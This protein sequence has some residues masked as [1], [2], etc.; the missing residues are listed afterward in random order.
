MCYMKC[1]FAW[2]G[3]IAKYVSR[4]PNP[5]RALFFN[6]SFSLVSRQHPDELPARLVRSRHLR[7]RTIPSGEW[8]WSWSELVR[9]LFIEPCSRWWGR[10]S[11]RRARLKASTSRGY[12]PSLR[13]TLPWSSAAAT[14]WEWTS[15]QPRWPLRAG[16]FGDLSQNQI[17]YPEASDPELVDFYAGRHRYPW[18]PPKNTQQPLQQASIHCYRLSTP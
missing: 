12:P 18:S 6:F 13:R 5:A 16:L 8:G 15:T 3:L 9:I 4:E 10:R 14:S 17:V 11:M 7:G 1:L 2:A